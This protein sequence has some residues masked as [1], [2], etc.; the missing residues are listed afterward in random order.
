MFVPRFSDSEKAPAKRMTPEMTNQ[1]PITT[2]NAVSAPNGFLMRIRPAMMLITPSTATRPRPCSPLPAIE[3]I[4][5]KMPSIS[6][7]MPMI[8]AIVWSE[9]LGQTSTMSPA[10]SV[11]RP[12]SRNSHQRLRNALSSSGIGADT[13]D[14]SVGALWGR[15]NGM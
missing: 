14:S 15:V 1:M 8:T 9:M 13:G 11:S 5:S 2:T 6:R 12:N 7:K 3:A 10:A 4:S